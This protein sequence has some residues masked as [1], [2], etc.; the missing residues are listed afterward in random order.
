MR[1]LVLGFEDLPV[2]A[3]LEYARNLVCTRAGDPNDNTLDPLLTIAADMLA[4]VIKVLRT[5]PRV[6]QL[7]TPET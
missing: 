2:L 4:D 6:A 7:R 1:E 5:V 3:R